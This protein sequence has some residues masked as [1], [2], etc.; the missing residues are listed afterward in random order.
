MTRVT[1]LDLSLTATGIATAAGTF[2]VKPKTSGV[3]R[4]NEFYGRALALAPGADIAVIESYSFGSRYGREAM[5]ALGGVVRLALYKER[6]PFVVVPPNC[7]KKFATGRGDASKDKMLAAAVRFCPE[8]EDN[9]EAD[10][11][12]LRQMGLFHYGAADVPTTQYRIDMAGGID[13]PELEVAA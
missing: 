6:V 1:G 2:L 12:W 9:N 10:A 5:G 8:I 13:W 11:W 4:L 3:E 7:L